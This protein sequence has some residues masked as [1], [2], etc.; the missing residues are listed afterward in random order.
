MENLILENIKNK[1]IEMAYDINV[2]HILQKILL[3]I[4]DAKRV[5]LNNITIENIKD[6]ALDINSVFVLKK[7]MATTTIVQNKNKISEIFL[8]S[9]R[10]LCYTIFI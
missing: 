1:E 9:F 5:E 6:F 4:L 8:K 3:I 2:T 7:F 10:K